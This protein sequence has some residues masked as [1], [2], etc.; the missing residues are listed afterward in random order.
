MDIA[1]ESVGLNYV[2]IWNAGALQ[3]KDVQDAM[4]AGLQKRKATFSKL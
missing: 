3:T 4:L 1:D 2:K